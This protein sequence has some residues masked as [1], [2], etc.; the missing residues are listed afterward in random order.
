MLEWCLCWGLGVDALKNPEVVQVCHR[1]ESVEDERVF[2]D[3]LQVKNYVFNIFV[4][5][6]SD[7]GGHILRQLT[8]KMLF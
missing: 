1:K 4:W 7:D 2:K 3:P 6:L 8:L 5:L